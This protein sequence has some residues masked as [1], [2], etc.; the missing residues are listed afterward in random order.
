MGWHSRRSQPAS[1]SLASLPTEW[2]LLAR[3][4]FCSS[5]WHGR[6]GSMRAS[7]VTGA[8]LPA[9][10]DGRS[11][12]CPCTPYG[13]HWWLSCSRRCSATVDAPRR[14]LHRRIVLTRILLGARS[15]LRLLV[16]QRQHRIDSRGAP[17]G[18]VTGEQGDDAERGRC[19]GNREGIVRSDAEELILD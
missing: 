11:P 18:N 9:W 12:I 3:I 7:S 10:S 16:P 14:A 15:C 6:R 13:R 19:G 2:R 17:R 8:R 4:S 1:P 5:T